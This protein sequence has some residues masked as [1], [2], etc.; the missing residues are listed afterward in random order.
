MQQIIEHW[1]SQHLEVSAWDDS[2]KGRQISA[3]KHLR[4]MLFLATR[5]A[6]FF[7]LAGVVSC[8]ECTGPACSGAEQHEIGLETVVS[9]MQAQQNT[10]NTQLQGCLA[11]NRLLMARENRARLLR[12]GGLQ[13]ILNTMD[14]HADSAVLQEAALEILELLVEAAE[15]DGWDAPS[16][17]GMPP[18][19]DNPDITAHSFCV[20]L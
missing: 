5:L 12:A 4:R 20:W 2:F 3:R 14:I 17:K 9:V 1:T 11:L 19:I 18:T 15:I 6:V 8:S 10:L 13:L 7:C 16:L